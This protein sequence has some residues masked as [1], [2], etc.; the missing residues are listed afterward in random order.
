MSSWFSVWV[1]ATGLVLERTTPKLAVRCHSR[2]L[3]LM[4][5]DCSPIILATILCVDPSQP[6]PQTPCSVWPEPFISKHFTESRSLW[7]IKFFSL[8][9]NPVA[10]PNPRAQG[11]ASYKAQGCLFGSRKRASAGQGPGHFVRL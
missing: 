11:P 1:A 9:H 7:L 4:R 2:A 8:F 6:Y 10:V 3:S 5:P